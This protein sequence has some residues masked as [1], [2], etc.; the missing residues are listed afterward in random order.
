MMPS[1][2]L[3]VPDVAQVPANP[4]ASLSLVDVKNLAVSL[5]AFAAEREWE[6]FHSPK[7]LAMAL[8]GEVGELVE[9]FQWMT[10]E[11]SRCALGNPDQATA[12]AEEMADVL[13]YLVRLADVLGINLDEAVKSKLALNAK[14]YPAAES[15]GSSKK[16]A[17]LA[18]DEGVA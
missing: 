10:E 13:L 14:K 15:R 18:S 7:N 8:T 11:E 6:Q 9:I 12:I 5:R 2:S 17:Y 4:S 3:N 1:N 16:R